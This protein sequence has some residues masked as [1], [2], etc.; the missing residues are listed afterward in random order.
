M[1]LNTT[2]TFHNTRDMSNFDHEEFLTNLHDEYT[3]S[4]LLKHKCW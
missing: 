2:D 1:M 4:N 3:N